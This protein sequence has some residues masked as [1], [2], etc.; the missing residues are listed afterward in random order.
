METQTNK[1]D[2]WLPASIILAA[3]L[4]AG[5]LIYNV[6]KKAGSPSELS[7]A[8]EESSLLDKVR[9][10]S[11]T[12]HVAGAAN[13]SA[14]DSD[15]NAAPVQVIE[16]SDLECPFCKTFHAT[17]ARIF[18]EYSEQITWAYRHFPLDSI[19]PKAR[20]E[21]LAA[22][23][24]A[25]LGGNDKFWE[26]LNEIFAVTPSN[27]GLNPE[28]LPRLAGKIG[29]NETQFKACQ[30]D[31]ALM[32]R[33]DADLENAIAAGG[34]GTPFTIVIGR[35]G[36]RYLIN[37]AQPYEQVKLIIDQALVD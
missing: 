5:A 9:S 21:A 36:G 20:Q 27:N 30:S 15:G 14:S 10:I 29:I 1:K 19:H 26:Y 8:E 34:R 33:V 12:D 3:L 13:L 7:Q 16:Y 25:S 37:G 4:I 32:S 28:E 22:E 18:D 2:Y 11:A 31:G 35:N 23:C 6:G 24:V 17:M